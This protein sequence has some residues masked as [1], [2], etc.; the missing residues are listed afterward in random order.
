MDREDRGEYE[1]RSPAQ[2]SGTESRRREVV[3]AR[4]DQERAGQD[5]AECAKAPSVRFGPA[6]CITRLFMAT[7][8]PAG[9]GTGNGETADIAGADGR[10]REPGR[11][12]GDGTGRV[13]G[14]RGEAGFL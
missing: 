1:G 8:P 10:V 12:A 4:A 11:V 7:S 3:G 14:E 9:I 2:G 6:P 5:E 13:E